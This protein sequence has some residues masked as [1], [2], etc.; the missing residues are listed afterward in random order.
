MNP[1]I[2]IDERDVEHLFEESLHASDQALTVKGFAI[3]TT[4]LLVNNALSSTSSPVSHRIFLFLGVE[5][6]QVVLVLM[7]GARRRKQAHAIAYQNVFIAPDSR[8]ETRMKRLRQ[9]GR[10]PLDTWFAASESLLI[11]LLAS[12]GCIGSMSQLASDHHPGVMII[13]VTWLI[14]IVAGVIALWQAVFKASI[15]DLIEESEALW[16]SVDWSAE[17]RH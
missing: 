6:L 17:N 4:A 13:S 3:A 2:S 10:L 1:E 15:S 14:N 11:V 16:R 5:M 12:V 7:I 9:S 8:Y